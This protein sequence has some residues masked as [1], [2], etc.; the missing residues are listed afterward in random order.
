MAKLSILKVG[1]CSHALFNLARSEYGSGWPQASGSSGSSRVGSGYSDLSAG[2]RSR[3]GMS[4]GGGR[5]SFNIFQHDG[6]VRAR[7]GLRFP[8][9]KAHLHTL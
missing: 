5:A 1:S 4:S 9:R 7:V 6:Q 3:F 8:Y 2:S